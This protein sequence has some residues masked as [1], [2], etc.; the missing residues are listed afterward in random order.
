MNQIVMIYLDLGW[1]SRQTDLS[2][3]ETVPNM[4]HETV[5]FV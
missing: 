4:I 2:S 5:E 1:E 3:V